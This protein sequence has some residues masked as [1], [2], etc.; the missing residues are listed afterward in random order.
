MSGITGGVLLSRHQTSCL[1]ALAFF[2]LLPRSSKHGSRF[3]HLSLLG[4]FENGF[5]ISQQSKC[6]CLLTYFDRLRKAERENDEDFMKRYITIER[7]VLEREFCTREFW[8]S[9]QVPLGTFETH[10]EGFIE[11]SE[12]SLQVDFAN[13]FIG[14]GVL[15]QGNVQVMYI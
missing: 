4:I 13:E 5:F 11:E 6:L 3:Q 14:G 15:Q 1:L 12:G 10:K 2:N 8:L 7:K 9:S